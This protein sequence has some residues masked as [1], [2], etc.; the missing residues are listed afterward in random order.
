MLGQ[1]FRRLPGRAVHLHHEVEELFVIEKLDEFDDAWMV[2]D[3]KHESFERNDAQAWI[4]HPT[5]AW[6]LLLPNEFDGNRHTI[7]VAMGTYNEAE[8]TAAELV[9]NGVV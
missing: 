6:H 3:A 7:E 5:V 1:G 8:T 4:A 2:D 9:C